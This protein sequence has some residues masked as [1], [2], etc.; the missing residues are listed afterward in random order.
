[1][2]TENLNV[3]V[4]LLRVAPLA[5]GSAA[6]GTSGYS[7]SGVLPA[8]SQHLGIEPAAA[9][10]LVTLFALAC[11][12]SGPL[13]VALTR[14]WPKRRIAVVALLITGAGNAFTAMAPSLALL[15]TARIITAVGVAV[16]VPAASATAA[17]ITTGSR[18]ARAVAAV[19]GG[20]TVAL[21]LGV[22]ITTALL[23]RLGGYQGVFLLVMAACLL[24]AAAIVVVVPTAAT[25]STVASTLHQRPPASDGRV[26]CLLGA[27]FMATTG[28]FA[29]YTYITLVVQE[30]T[31]HDWPASVMLAAYGLGAVAGNVISGR[32]T[33]RWGAAWLLLI[34]TGTSCLALL[35]LTA[36]A[37]SPVGLVGV[38]MVWGGACWA[39]YVPAN[40][41][42]LSNKDNK[43]GSTLLS[44]NA[45]SV[46]AGM[47]TGGLVG[48]VVIEAAGV[49]TVPLVAAAAA[50]I[51]AGLAYLGAVRRR[52]PSRMPKP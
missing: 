4:S 36:A 40:V 32:L 49:G 3:P 18:R 52:E 23:S 25:A 45:S 11:A 29:V 1:M 30:S 13:M 26:L 17:A 22:P 46:Y 20:L 39:V 24:A 33:D 44:L 5:A 28:T 38:L 34:A 43:Q 12:T 48:G 16:Y 37:A 35:A 42:L 10:Q 15:V 31:M 9:G 41:L 21:L 19:I 27:T 2:S 51:A 6:T 8:L 47:A 7:V 14:A 50:V